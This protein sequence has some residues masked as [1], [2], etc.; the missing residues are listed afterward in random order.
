M[1]SKSL[2]EEGGGSRCSDQIKNGHKVI[3]MG[4]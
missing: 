3:E 2:A 1:G 4:T